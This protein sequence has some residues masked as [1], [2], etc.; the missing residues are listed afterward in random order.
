MKEGWRNCPTK[1][2]PALEIEA[3]VVNRL[4]A[5]GKDP[6]LQ[7]EVIGEYRRQTHEHHRSLCDRKKLLTRERSRIRR[8]ATKAKSPSGDAVAVQLL[9]EQ[10]RDTE[11]A[12]QQVENELSATT[13]EGLSNA[14]LSAAF[15]SFDPIW[16]RLT[17]HE[18][19]RL[20][21]TLI[22]QIRFNGETGDLTIAF[23]NCGIHTL[24]T[25]GSTGD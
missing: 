14:D 19:C 11:L 23:H 4:K 20:I 10:F 24:A 3:F 17:Q 1:S 7:D 16:N 6:A 8:A 2:V 9:G 15:Q 5:I 18:R 25:G 21:A 12:L 22:D 13:G